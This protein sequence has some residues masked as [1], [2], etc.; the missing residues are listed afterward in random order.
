MNDTSPELRRLA[1]LL[2][3]VQKEDAHLLA[4]RGRLIPKGTI[5]DMPWLEATIADDIGADRLEAFSSRFSRMQDTVTDKLIPQLLVAA[6]EIPMAA[7]DNLNRA[8]RL[9]FIS[10]SDTWL[11]MRRLRNRL[12]H[13]YI[14][15]LSEML[16]ALKKAYAFT[17]ELHNTFKSIADYARSRLGIR[18]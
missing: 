6:G 10:S 8:E 14:D 7:I 9:N 12:V 17:D 3:L 4:V 16:P 13:E 15:D 1:Q 5:I 11:E 18:V 2:D